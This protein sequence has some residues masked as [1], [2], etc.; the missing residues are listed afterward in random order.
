MLIRSDHQLLGYMNQLFSKFLPSTNYGKFELKLNVNIIIYKQPTVI[1]YYEIFY[2]YSY[3][4]HEW[5]YKCPKERKNRNA[6]ILFIFKCLQLVIHKMVND[7][8]VKYVGIWIFIH[9]FRVLFVFSNCFA[10]YN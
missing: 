3:R 6:S 2:E 10:F 7:M 9:T 5:L 8:A 1:M 4:Q